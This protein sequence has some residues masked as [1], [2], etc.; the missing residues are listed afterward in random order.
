MTLFTVSVCNQEAN[1][2][3][4]LIQMIKQPNDIF[5]SLVNMLKTLEKYDVNH[6]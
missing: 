5:K 3:C 2:P 1:S 6:V 4:H